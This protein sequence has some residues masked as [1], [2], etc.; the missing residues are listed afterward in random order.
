[1]DPKRGLGLCQLDVRLPE[2]LGRPVV[3]VR[4]QDV[5]ALSEAGLI[6]PARADRPVESQSR[7]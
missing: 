4:A 7:R 2:G 6:V 3:D 5:T 1:V